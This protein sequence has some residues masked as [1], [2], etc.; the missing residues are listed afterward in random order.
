MDVL[1][2]YCPRLVGSAAAFFLFALGVVSKIGFWMMPT[3]L[4]LVRTVGSSYAVWAAAKVNFGSR[5][6][7]ICA[8]VQRQ[9]L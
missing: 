3:A 7:H 2:V 1:Q 6:W 8:P 5:R 4:C 9:L